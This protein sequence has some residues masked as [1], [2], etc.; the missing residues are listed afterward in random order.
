[1]DGSFGKSFL[2]PSSRPYL[3]FYIASPYYNNDIELCAHIS[4]R[5]IGRF[6]QDRRS[7]LGDPVTCRRPGYV[8]LVKRPQTRRLNASYTRPGVMSDGGEGHYYMQGIALCTAA[9]F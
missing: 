7:H 4:W 3:I 6:L 1:M 2:R 5:K 9:H 8:R